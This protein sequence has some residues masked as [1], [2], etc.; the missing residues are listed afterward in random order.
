[1]PRGA[2]VGTDG[3]RDTALRVSRI[4]RARARLREHEDVAFALERGRGAQ[5][6]DAAPDYQ[7]IGLQIFVIVSPVLLDVGSRSGRYGIHIE[8]GLAARSNINGLLDAAGVPKRRFLVSNPTVWRFHDHAFTGLTAEEPILIPDGER[9]KN[10]QTVGRIYDALIRAHAD[11]ASAIVAIGGGVLGDT[12]GFAAATYLRGVS[13]VQVPTTLLAQVDSAVGGKVGV[14]H[15]QGKNLI[16]AFHP[17]AL[18]IVDPALLSTLP[19]REFRAGLYEVIKYGLIASR[20]LFDR[21]ATSLPAL[22]NRD[23][24]ALM[25]IV[26]ESCRIKASVVEEDERETG[27]RRTL[28]LGHTA[29]HALEAVTKYRRFRHGEAVGYGMLVAAEIATA[30]GVMPPEDRDALAALIAKMGPLPAVADLPVADALDAIAHDKKVVAGQLHYVLPKAIGGCDVVADVT[31]D[32][33]AAALK[34]IGM[35]GNS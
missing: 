31:K 17:P 24:D 21:V 34:S 32:E 9:Y 28:N 18:V 29:G 35:R 20:P 16:G 2:V 26:T 30:R 6:R 19:R 1:M 5:R 23:P 33:I 14:N 27:V 22:F 13:L 10:L 8:P 25:A 15:A 3:R 12:A 11:R 7:E 4:P